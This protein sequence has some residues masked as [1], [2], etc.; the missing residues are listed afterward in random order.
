MMDRKRIRFVVCLFLFLAW[1]GALAAMALTTARQPRAS[2]EPARAAEPLPGA[3][4]A[5]AGLAR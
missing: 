4:P 3:V 1:V 2:T 5:E